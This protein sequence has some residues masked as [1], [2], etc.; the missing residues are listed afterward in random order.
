MKCV[1]EEVRDI[2]ED[3][4]KEKTKRWK[5]LRK[6]QKTSARIQ[7]SKQ[8]FQKNRADKLDGNQQ[9]NSLNSQT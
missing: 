4:Q 8:E 3:I 9:Q 5:I 6:N 7:T 2:Y 1:I